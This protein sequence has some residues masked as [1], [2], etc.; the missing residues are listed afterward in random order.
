MGFFPNTFLLKQ[1]SFAQGMMVKLAEQKKEED[2]NVNSL[3]F[4]GKYKITAGFRVNSKKR[5]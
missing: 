1:P 2:F 5:S 3:Q 4:P